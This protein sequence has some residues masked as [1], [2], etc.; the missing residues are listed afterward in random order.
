MSKFSKYN[1]LMKSLKNKAFSPVYFFYGEEVFFINRLCDYIENNV[2]D[3]SLRSF[4]QF[5]VYGKDITGSGLVEMVMR[6][7]MMSEK[8]LVIV[9]D[10][11]DV[12]GTEALIPLI[13]K[14]VPSTVLVLIYPK[15]KPD[16]R[17]KI[18]K[19]ILQK[20]VTFES[21]IIYDNQVP[22][23]L[24]DFFKEFGL[25]YEPATIALLSEYVGTDVSNMYNEIE[26]LSLALPKGHTVKAKDIEEL[27]G[28]SKE[29]TVFELQKALAV[30]D[31]GKCFKILQN[32]LQHTKNNHPTTIISVL[33]T[34]VHKAMGIR[35]IQIS[36]QD[37]AKKIGVNPFFVKDYR[38]FNNSYTFEEHANIIEALLMYDLMYKGV[39]GDN[40]PEIEKM[41]ELL[42][43]IFSKNKI[44]S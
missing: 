8:Q 43:I 7:P 33:F 22:A 36:D 37:A 17:L 30:K 25:A 10:F 18:F 35:G 19:S 16:S 3:A 21:P 24:E 41:N 44:S 31:E 5:L 9:K 26:K 38:S 29:Y 32:L 27:T 20:S 13:E 2:I 11:Q 42:M 15:G 40:T 4:N 34:F 28:I 12:K 39:M 14:P 1:E 23:L 6:Y